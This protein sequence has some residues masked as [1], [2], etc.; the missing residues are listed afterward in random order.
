MNKSLFLRSDNSLQS[1]SFTH[2]E[3]SLLFES[4]TKQQ[5]SSLVTSVPCDLPL[6]ASVTRTRWRSQH[7]HP[8]HRRFRSCLK[9]ARTAAI[10]NHATSLSHPGRIESPSE[11]QTS[12]FSID[13]LSQD[14][15]L[16]FT[17]LAS[18]SDCLN[19]DIPASVYRLRTSSIFALSTC[20]P[21]K[22]TK[23]KHVPDCR[24][25]YR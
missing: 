20:V 22:Q 19:R 11:K 17:I 9:N 24:M 8:L 21:N 10:P 4:F 12:H 7:P 13:P 6:K 16:N 18:K 2:S 14:G 15:H 23:V 25:A 3:K 1:N 5:P